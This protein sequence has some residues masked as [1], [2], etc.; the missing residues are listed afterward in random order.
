[1]VKTFYRP[2]LYLRLHE[3]GLILNSVHIEVSGSRQRKI[4]GQ[5]NRSKSAGFENSNLVI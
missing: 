5:E 4:L 3:T 2:T 1:M